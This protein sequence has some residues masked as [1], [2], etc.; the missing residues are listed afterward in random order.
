MNKIRIYHKAPVTIAKLL[1]SELPRKGMKMPICQA[2]FLFIFTGV[3]LFA[4]DAEEAANPEPAPSSPARP[5]IYFSKITLWHDIIFQYDRSFYDSLKSNVI[6]A[7]EL[8]NYL[9]LE[10]GLEIG[11]LALGK[12]YTTDL[13]N[14]FFTVDYKLP[15]PIK[16]WGVFVGASYKYN[17]LFQYETNAHSLLPAISVRS[18]LAGL[19]L[20]LT[21]RWTSFFYEKSIT[22]LIISFKIYV[23][24]INREKIKFDFV[25]ANFD[26]FNCGNFGS[27][28]LNL[29]S[30]IRVH[31]QLSLVNELELNQSGSIGLTAN[32][33]GFRY[34][35]GIQWQR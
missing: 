23:N 16:N 15:I 13:L 29:T 21:S 5:W 19:S 24:I 1:K 12:T 33:Y 9:T 7:L 14:T 3:F 28:F 35:A 8:N 25:I 31:K 10:S 17:G 18:G 6:A 26:E 11:T 20:G 32:F 30:L 27:Y 34:K 2:V 4:K 22:E